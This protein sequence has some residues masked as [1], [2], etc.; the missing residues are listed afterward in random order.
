[1]HISTQYSIWLLEMARSNRLERTVTVNHCRAQHSDVAAWLH[2]L[3]VV[4]PGCGRFGLV[5]WLGK[6]VSRYRTLTDPV[7]LQTRSANGF[8]FIAL[9]IASVEW[10]GA[11][12]LYNLDLAF[13]AS[14]T[15]L[16]LDDSGH[17]L[18]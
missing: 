17:T 3:P 9:E 5:F 12:R 18:Q 4:F 16:A 11:D 1:M 7:P 2:D 15:T 14:A 13:P 8:G 6:L 10:L